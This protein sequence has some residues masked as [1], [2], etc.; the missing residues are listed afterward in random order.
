MRILFVASGHGPHKEM[1]PFTRAQA[2]SLRRI[3]LTI[4]SFPI[5]GQGLRAYVR[6]IPQLRKYLRENPPDVIHAHYSLSGWV[7]VAARPRQPIVLSLMGTDAYGEYVGE[8]KVIPQSR[9][10]TLLTW[11]IQPFVQ[12]IICKSAN[13]AA[14]SY[15]PGITEILPNGVE[16]DKFELL[17]HEATRKALGLRP[18]RRYVLFLGDPKNPRKNVALA[19]RA[20]SLLQRDDVELLLPYPIPHSEVVRY[21]NAADAFVLCSYMEGSPNVV[22]EAMACNCPLVVTDVGDAAW[23][24]GDEPGCYVASFDPAD[25]AQKLE[26]ALQFGSKG[27]R[28]GGRERLHTLGLEAG[29]VAD[30]LKTIYHSLGRATP[31]K[32]RAGS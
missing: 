23:L 16:L 32:A 24:V 30:R 12:K 1:A 25:F 4:N 28:T 2:S 15:R 10:L 14:Y 31:Q 19:R 11:L 6:A 7:A 26:L 22:K 20:I 9:L 5:E 27:Q 18:D 3:G 29:Q 8:N 13:I 21:F 17:P